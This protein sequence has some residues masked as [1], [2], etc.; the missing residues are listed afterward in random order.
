MA[1]EI[2][3]FRDLTLVGPVE[4]RP[5]LRTALIKAAVSPWKVDLER[6][7]EIKRSAVTNDDVVIFR[8]D[9]GGK[10]PAAGLT[11]WENAKGYY[12][13]NIVPLEFGSLTYFQYN[14]VLEDFIERIASPVVLLFSYSIETTEP[15]QVLE[16]WVSEEVARKLRHFSDA[17]NKS[18]GASHPMDE[19]GWFEFI[20]AVH[21][22]GDRLGADRLARWLHEAE[23][24]DEN[25]A[26][27]LAGDYENSLSLLDYYD[28]H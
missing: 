21:R 16:D 28:K 10:L 5:A 25:I 18:T 20:I 14:A 17:A 3:M 24:W 15:H 27:D 26:H 12:V 2:E 7:A 8:R 23:H 6:S 4:Q 1:D 19:R 11:L 22:S 13:P 9:A